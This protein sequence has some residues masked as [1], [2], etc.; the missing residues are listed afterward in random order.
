[1]AWTEVPEKLESLRKQRGR[2]YRGLRESLFYHRDMMFR[3]KYGRIGWFALP[4]FWL[5]EYYGRCWRRWATCS[6]WCSSSWG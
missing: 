5:F 2:W 1:M 6:C 3:R 4:S